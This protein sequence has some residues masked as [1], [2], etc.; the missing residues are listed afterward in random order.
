MVLFVLSSP[1]HDLD[2][3]CFAI[4]VFPG[5]ATQP[6]AVPWPAICSACWTTIVHHSP[7]WHSWWNLAVSVAADVLECYVEKGL[8]LAGWGHQ[9]GWHGEH[10]PHPQHQQR[11]RLAGDPEM[12]ST[13]RQVR[14]L[15]A[16]LD[17]IRMVLGG[18]PTPCYFTTEFAKSI[19][20]TLPVVN[21]NEIVRNTSD[22]VKKKSGL[23]CSV[24][25]IRSCWCRCGS[26]FLIT[27]DNG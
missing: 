11:E 12:G 1:C 24:R 20:F 21:D 13:A 17:E 8:A 25:Y 10:H 15:N 18:Q 9:S 7:G 16:L 3:V 26:Q 27:L 4:C 22:G 2:K 14:D 6:A 19:F 23:I 5:V